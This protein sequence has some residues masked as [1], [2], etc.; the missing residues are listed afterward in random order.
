MALARTAYTLG[1]GTLVAARLVRRLKPA[2]VVGFGGYP[3]LP[4]LIAARLL[5][6][7]GII[8]DAIAVLGRATAFS[9]AASTRLP[10]R[11]RACSIAILISPARR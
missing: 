6:V 2:A 5:G 7:P 4:P 3:T 8:H 9:P 10:P 1:Y 11:C